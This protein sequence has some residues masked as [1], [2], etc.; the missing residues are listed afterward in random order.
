MNNTNEI[1]HLTKDEF[2][3]VISGAVEKALRGAGP[4]LSPLSTS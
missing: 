2:A 1:I 4:P 3:A